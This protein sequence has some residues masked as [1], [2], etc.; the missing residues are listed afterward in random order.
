MPP[1]KHFVLLVKVLFVDIV[2]LLVRQNGLQ[3]G[4]TSIN[5][6]IPGAIVPTVVNIT[7]FFVIRFTLFAALVLS[8]HFKLTIFVTMIYVRLH[9]FLRSLNQS[10]LLAKHDVGIG[11]GRVCP[12]QRVLIARHDTS[13]VWNVY[14]A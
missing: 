11:A 3:F 8:L 14:S 4:L 7:V 9:L 12:A 6:V 1:T 13:I 2:P 10:Q 5:S